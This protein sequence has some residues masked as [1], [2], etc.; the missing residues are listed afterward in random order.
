M[1]TKLKS[2]HMHSSEVTEVVKKKAGKYKYAREKKKKKEE[3]FS[4][5]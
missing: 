4:S 2:M 3:E 5:P 1:L